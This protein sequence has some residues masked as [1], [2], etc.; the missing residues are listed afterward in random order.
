MIYASLILA[1]LISSRLHVVDNAASDA[2][3]LINFK[4]MP[5][6]D[7]E[8]DVIGSSSERQSSGCM[9]QSVYVIL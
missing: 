8:G 5:D 6:L 2:K 3:V 1:D 9:I 7:G 4:R